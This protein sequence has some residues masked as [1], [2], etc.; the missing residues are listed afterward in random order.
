MARKRKKRKKGKN[1]NSFRRKKRNIPERIKS[2]IAG[3]VSM[4]FALFFLLSFFDLAGIAGR[5]AFK[6]F[7]I[8]V[9]QT[10]FI[11]PLVFLLAGLSFF[12]TKLKDKWLIGLATT[13][14]V[15]AVSGILATIE[16]RKISPLKFQFSE[17]GGWIGAILSW[18]LLRI[19]GFWVGEIIFL[20][21]ISIAIIIF[22][23]FLYK[24]KEEKEEKKKAKIEEPLPQKRITIKKVFAPKFKVKSIEEP[25]LPTAPSK[26]EKEKKPL[27][28]IKPKTTNAAELEEAIKLPPLDLLEEERG[29]ATAGDIQTNSQIIKRTLENFGISVEMS[30]INVGPTVTQY[31]LKPAEGVKLSKITA[32][33]NNLALALAA[34]PIRIEA[35]IPG[36]PL[37]G[38][39]VPN[40][41]RA[42]VRLRNLL[43]DPEFQSFPSSLAFALG[44]DVVGNP[45]FADLA[46]MPHLL[47]AGSTGTGKTICLS[48]IILS[49]LYKNT[50]KTLRLILVDPKRVEFTAYN[51]L[52]HLLAPVVYDVS[53]TVKVLRWLI[54][55]MEKRFEIL[56]QVGTRNITLFNKKLEH[57]SRLK[58]EGFEYMSFIILIIDELA[59][60]MA[61][62]GRDVEA[63]I[64]R[65]AQ[66]ARAVGIHLILATQRPSVEV[67]TGLIKANIIARIAFQ[68]ASQIDSRTILD[69]AGAEK[70]LGNG[71]MLF[72]SSSISK[73]KRIQGAYVSEREIER[74]SEFISKNQQ[75]EGIDTLSQSL[76][77]EI[78][79][80][81]GEE[82]G[83]FFETGEDPLYE[84]AKR[85]VIETRKASASFLQRRLRVG[86]ARAARL[87]DML[88]ERGIIGPARGAKPRDVYGVAE[89]EGG[90]T[91]EEDF[92]KDYNEEID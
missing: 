66:K 69:M 4:F 52:P 64:V 35:P 2:L 7:S 47:V 3:A 61:A 75:I 91:E 15:L 55:E 86:Y 68:V 8:L 13:F 22:W 5:W 17:N 39:E 9:G 57:N 50:P 16:L 88:E 31:T 42:I 92:G 32:L 29:K 20:I 37:V 84:E 27:L 85:L 54:N 67:I 43:A 21:L 59:D 46:R 24:P 58:K 65:L 79:R 14:L 34:H 48:S 41:K 77:Q 33:A 71:D 62:R 78:E 45:V 89:E 40:Q 19:F 63:G 53:K 11:F 12:S 74:V 30:G 87:L 36:K 10:I 44:R 56:S 81:E 90:G 83:R 80:P 1:K 18:P 28:E 6:G 82:T 49:L 72:I 25:T 76:E 73:P 51:H 23:Q 38:I 60:L 70:L 26:E